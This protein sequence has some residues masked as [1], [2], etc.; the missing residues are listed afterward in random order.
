MLRIPRF[1]MF[2]VVHDLVTS[3]KKKGTDEKGVTPFKTLHLTP[4]WA[5]KLRK[6]TTAL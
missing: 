1:G 2:N 5:E 4:S 6:S 3:E